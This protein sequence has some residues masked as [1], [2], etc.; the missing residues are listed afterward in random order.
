[1]VTGTVAWRRLLRAYLRA[2]ALAEPLQQELAR[3]YGVSLADMRAIRV[4]GDSGEMPTSRLGAALSMH[5]STTTSLVDRL[6]AAGLVVRQRSG[7]DRRVTTVQITPKGREALTD[8]SLIRD[9]LVARRLAELDP[10]EQVQL[11]R[12]LERVVDGPGPE[13][14]PSVGP[15]DRAARTGND[16]TSERT[17]E[18]TNEQ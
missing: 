1:V 6:E 16:G 18:R 14:S 17:N 2:V 13:N 3:R 11:A 12:L 4:L 5:R 9:S 15:V 8:I 7:P 10:Y